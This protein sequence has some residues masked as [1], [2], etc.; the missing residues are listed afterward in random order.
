MLRLGAG[1]PRLEQARWRVDVTIST[2]SLSKCL[3]PSVLIQL[4]LSDGRMKN[5]ELPIDKFHDLRFNVAK[6]LR[7][8]GEIESHPLIRVIHHVDDFER[9]DLEKDAAKGKK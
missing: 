9:K 4:T 8:M 3:V 2:S 7:A 5:F 1:C 6:A